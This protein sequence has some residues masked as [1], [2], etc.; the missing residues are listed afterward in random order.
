MVVPSKIESFGQ[1]ASEAQA[2][3]VP[4]VAFNATGLKDIIKHKQTGF[5]AKPYNW[6]EIYEGIVWLLN[7]EKQLKKLKLVLEKEL[8]LC[9]IQI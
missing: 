2:C 7:N 8:S 5:L 9:G 6:E 1:T 3:G 4:V